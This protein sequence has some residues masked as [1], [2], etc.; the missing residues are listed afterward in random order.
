MR[1]ILRTKSIAL[2]LALMLLTTLGHAQIQKLA[3]ARTVDG[4]AQ[5]FAVTPIS[6]GTNVFTNYKA[7]TDPNAP[8]VGWH[9]FMGFTTAQDITVAPLSD[10][11]LQVFVVSPSGLWSTWKVSTGGGSPWTKWNYF[12]FNGYDPQSNRTY[13]AVPPITAFQLS[14]GRM[15]VVVKNSGDGNFYTL[16]KTSTDPNSGWS[17]PPARF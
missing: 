13:N 14:D 15:Q 5:V 12:K 8:W 11:R 3:G 17:W 16:W 1:N 9:S 6:G 7:T 10:G 2:S 4:I